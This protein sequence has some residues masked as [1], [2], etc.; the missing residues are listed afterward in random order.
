MGHFL[1]LDRWGAPSEAEQRNGMPFHGEASRVLWRLV[2]E[3]RL[4]GEHVESEMAAV[5][6]LAGLQVT[7]RIR[8]SRDAAFFTVIERVTNTNPLGRIYNMVQHPTI[9]PPFLDEHTLVDSNGTRGFMQSGPLPDPEKVSVE[10]PYASDKGGQ[11]NL[12][13]LGAESSP[14]VVSYTIEDEYGWTTASSASRGLLIGYIWKA[15]DY[16]W[17]N[18]WRHAENGVPAARGLEFGTTGLHQPFPILVRKGSIF[19]RG[20]FAYLDAS[21]TAT[22][23]YGGFLFPVPAD[24]MGVAKITYASGELRLHEHEGRGNRTLTMKIGDL[25]RE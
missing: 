21:E 6:P 7:R 2:A 22:R 14:N 19:G 17:F 12:R 11:V 13:R 5:L 1:C 16:P 25:F 8:L 20:L 24:Y 10:W 23:S 4:K 18:A 3:P 15:S 9:A